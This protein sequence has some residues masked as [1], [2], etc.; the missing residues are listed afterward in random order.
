MT[1]NPRIGIV[2][3]AVNIDDVLNNEIGAIVRM[4]QAGAVQDLGSAIHC[5]ADTR[6]HCSTWISVG[7][8]ENRRNAEHVALNP[9]AM[10]STTK[11]AGVQATVDAAAAQVEVMVR[12][13]SEGMR[14]MFKPTS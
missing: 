2:D 9:D 12:N 4:R 6:T 11:A 13:L 5:W 10:Q 3:G 8:A 7:R 1:N 14:R